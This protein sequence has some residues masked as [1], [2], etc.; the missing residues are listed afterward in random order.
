MKLEPKKTLKNKMYYHMEGPGN[1]R[2]HIH[3]N[4]LVHVPNLV[5]IQIKEPFNRNEDAI[6][7][8][9]PTYLAVYTCRGEWDGRSHLTAELLYIA[10]LL[11]DVWRLKNVPNV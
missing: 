7:G 1:W 11:G 8:T 2:A 6:T 4:W 5:N 10:L 3:C 9:S